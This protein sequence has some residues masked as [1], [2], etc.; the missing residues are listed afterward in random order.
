VK[1]VDTTT[2]ALFTE[3]QQHRL[4]ASVRMSNGGKTA[5]LNPARNLRIGRIYTIRLLNG[6]RDYAGNPVSKQSWTVTVK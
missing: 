5:T 2:M 1:G 4:S 6:I 3:G